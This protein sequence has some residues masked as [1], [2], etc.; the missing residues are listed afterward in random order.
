MQ[1]LVAACRDPSVAMDVTPHRLQVARAPHARGRTRAVYRKSIDELYE[2]LN[3][4]EGPQSATD[5]AR[6]SSLGP[7][8]QITRPHQSPLRQHPRQHHLLALRLPRMRPRPTRRRT[9]PALH[10]QPL[11]DA[12]R[13]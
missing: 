2:M 8:G 10:R 7:E 12:A 11:A 1:V 5:R 4:M 13:G 9:P 3:T 6:L